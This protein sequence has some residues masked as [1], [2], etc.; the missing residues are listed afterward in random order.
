MVSCL[1]VSPYM[2]SAHMTLAHRGHTQQGRGV[3]KGLKVG[4]SN[5]QL[6]CVWSWKPCVTLGQSWLREPGDGTRN[7][8]YKTRPRYKVAMTEGEQRLE[9][10]CAPFPLKLHQELLQVQRPL[11]PQRACRRCLQVLSTEPWPSRR[12]SVPSV[13]S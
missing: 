4:T 9:A 5:I 12:G 13:S 6:C 2:W 11:C 3:G 7:L 10:T 1:R 8:C